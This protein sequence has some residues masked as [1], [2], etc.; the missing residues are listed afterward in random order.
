MALKLN[1]YIFH[2]IMIK[3][4][5][6]WDPSNAGSSDGKLSKVNVSRTETVLFLSHK[7]KC[8]WEAEDFLKILKKRAEIVNTFSKVEHNHSLSNT[9]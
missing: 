9:F 4:K 7:P 6:V 8:V 5:C 2:S 1:R 3:S